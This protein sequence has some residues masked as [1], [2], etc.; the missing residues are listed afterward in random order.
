MRL[1]VKLPVV[2]VGAI[3][4][5]AAASGVVAVVIGRHVLRQAALNESV[6]R[7]EIYSSAIVYYV[8]SARSLLTTTAESPNLT[9]VAGARN[10]AARVLA[11]SGVFEYVMFLT[12]DGMVEMLEPRTLEERLSH[13]DL[14]FN[15]WFGEVRRTNRTVVS[16]LHISPATQRPTIVIATPVSAADGRTL[17]FWVGALKLGELSE[18]GTVASDGIASSGWGYV[19]DRRGL[20]IAHQALPTYVENQTDFSA[21]P[22]VHAA[23]AGQTGSGEIFNMIENES[24]LTAYR[25]LPDLSWAVVYG[26]PTSIALAPLAALTRGVLWASVVLAVLIGVAMLF[27]ARRTVTPLARLTAAA[28]IVGTGDLNFRTGLAGD[29]EIGELSRAFDRMVSHL[30]KSRAEIEYKAVQLEAANKELEAFSYSAS[31]D[32]RAPLQTIAG[33]SRALEEDYS[34]YLDA[35]A[36][37]YLQRLRAAAQHM[38]RL[39]DDLLKLSRL[40]RAEMVLEPVDLGEI[41]GSVADALR[42]QDSMR[43][44]TFDIATGAT[45]QGDKRLLAVLMENLLGNAWKY[46]SKHLSARIEFGVGERDGERVYY[47]RD[48]GAGFDMAHA[49]KL[50]VPFQRLHATSDFAGNG[51]GLA[52]VRR[53]VVRHDGRVWGEAAP[54]KG[55]TFYFTIPGM[56]VGTPGSA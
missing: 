23:L 7:V 24:K 56:P 10:L 34:D 1:M 19:T 48:D 53:I 20:I 16:D 11:H 26:T 32:L 50:F 5:T 39:V 6:H 22:S 12:A 13:R 45:V 46:T 15:A 21:L 8:A 38:A 28:N 55:A 18:I 42:A 29:D 31:H 49:E 40:T 35:T 2:V 14:S 37:D 43:A 52:T 54:E 30:Q 3:L 27:L 17:G 51:V 25:P 4:F 36:K 44:V 9:T 33:F 47:V 41:A